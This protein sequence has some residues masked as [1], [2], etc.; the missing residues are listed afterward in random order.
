MNYKMTDL[1][2]YDQ[3]PSGIEKITVAEAIEQQKTAIFQR[4]NGTK[5]YEG[6]G[7]TDE[8]ALL[9]FMAI[10]WAWIEALD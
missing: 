9:D 7:L 4:F 2:C 6:D 3:Y 5:S 1:V 10:H 8:D